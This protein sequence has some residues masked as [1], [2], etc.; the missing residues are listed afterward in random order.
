MTRMCMSFFKG[1]IFGSGQGDFRCNKT[2]YYRVVCQ[3]QKHGYMV[4]DAA[5]LKGTAEEIQ[6]HHI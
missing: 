5:F 4:G 2:L 6:P 3:V 1:K